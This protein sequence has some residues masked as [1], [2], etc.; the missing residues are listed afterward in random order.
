MKKQNEWREGIPTLRNFLFSGSLQQVAR[1]KRSKMR[2]QSKLLVIA[3]GVKKRVYIN[4]CI[5]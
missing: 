4:P 3:A 2:V 5:T 1:M